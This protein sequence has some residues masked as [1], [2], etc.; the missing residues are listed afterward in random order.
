MMGDV[1]V[2]DLKDAIPLMV[3]QFK[4]DSDS[5][6]FHP[7][8]VFERTFQVLVVQWVV[9]NRAG[10][11]IK[12]ADDTDATAFTMVAAKVPDSVDVYGE[13]PTGAE[14]TPKLTFVVTKVGLVVVVGAVVDPSVTFLSP[15]LRGSTCFV[16]AK[17]G[18][19]FGC[20]LI[21]VK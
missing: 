21:K 20:C 13:T 7:S 11:D 8:K 15:E 18:A 19:C 3:A 16:R 1:P 10:I 14:R 2:I 6:G 4:G 5:V 9:T 12:F 17:I